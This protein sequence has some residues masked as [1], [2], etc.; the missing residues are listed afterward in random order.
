MEKL[1][2]GGHLSNAAC[3]LKDT[4]IIESELSLKQVID[5]YLEGVNNHESNFSTRCKR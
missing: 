3:Q 4:T 2:G 1:G 5:E